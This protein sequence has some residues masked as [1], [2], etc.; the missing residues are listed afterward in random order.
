[1]SNLEQRAYDAVRLDAAV[2][3]IIGTPA[4]IYEEKAP[5][6]PT[7]PLVTY[8]RISGR[9]LYTLGGYS[10]LE[11]PHL[12]FDCW[13][14]DS[15]TRDSLVTA[16]LDA[17]RAATTFAVSDD[18]DRHLEEDDPDLYRT[19]IDVSCWNQEA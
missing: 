19:A 15:A 2:Q 8:M 16:V 18:D 6:N 17:L 11:N 9:R 5:Q 3:A 12:Q 13:A 4:R 7:Y 14:R 10:N 1:M